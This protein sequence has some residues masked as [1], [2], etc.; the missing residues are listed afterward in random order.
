MDNGSLLHR[1]AD[2]ATDFL[3]GLDERPVGGP[4]D[5]AALRAAMGGPLPEEGEDPAAVIEAPGPRR[6]AGHRRDRRA[7]LLRVRH[8]RQ[9]CRRR[10][11]P[12][13]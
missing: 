2:L 11:R 8:R 12:T 5:L 4:V 1:T 10:S 3:D 6:G 9:R 13:G 7:A